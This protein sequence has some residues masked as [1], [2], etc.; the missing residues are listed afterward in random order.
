[1]TEL[2]VSGRS[3]LEAGDT[4]DWRSDTPMEVAIEMATASTSIAVETA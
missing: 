3:D 2:S 1:M 4:G